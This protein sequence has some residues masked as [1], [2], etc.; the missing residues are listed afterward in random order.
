MWERG[1]PEATALRP[2]L[3]IMLRSLDLILRAM[4]YKVPQGRAWK[5]QTLFAWGGRTEF[6]RGPVP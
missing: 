6:H 3:V 4:S 5:G 1:G 2:G